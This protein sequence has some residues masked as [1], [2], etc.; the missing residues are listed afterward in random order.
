ME[1]LAH[2]CRVTATFMSG[3]YPVAMANNPGAT[4]VQVTRSSALRAALREPRLVLTLGLGFASGLPLALSGAT[5]QAWLQESGVSLERIGATALIGLPYTLKPLWAPLLDRFTVG[6]LGRRRGWM[7]LTQAALTVVLLGLSTLD[8]AGSLGLVALAATLLATASATQDIAIDAWRTETLHPRHYGLGATLHIMGYRL[9]MLASGAGALILADH[10]PWSR[11]Y[12]LL[13]LAMAACIVFA[14]LAPEPET[15]RPRDL[16]TAVIEPLREFLTR[17]AATTVL[18]FVILYKLG[19]ALAAALVT[20]FL[21]ETGFSK[22]EIGTV[23]K[24]VGLVATIG[25]GL[26]GGA[27]LAWLGLLRA[28]LLFGLL[29]AVSNLGFMLVA[30]VGPQ[31]WVLATAVVVENLSG[32]MGTAAYAAFLMALCDQRF[33][34]T[35]YAVFTAL[36]ALTRTVAAAPS[37]VVATA[38]GWTIY[39]GLSAVAA[40]PGLLLIPTAARAI[41][42]REAG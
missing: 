38:T 26:A 13:A 30:L 39:Y 40:L 18:A 7:L 36:M 27:L 9:G 14:L 1:S 35:Q 5:L 32:G 12:Q 25:G 15:L 3:V 31:T 21:L 37:G 22:T 33:T 28:L 19:D 29:Q 10:L 42:A 16:R 17:P 2:C 20:P 6:P 4:E 8:P 24:A 23:Y 11:V 34:G 41:R